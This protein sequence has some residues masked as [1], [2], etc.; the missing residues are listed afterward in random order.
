MA[1]V[2]GVMAASTAP[3][4]MLNVAGSMSTNTGVPPALWMAPAVAKKV[5]GV[6]ITSSPGWRS[7]ALSGS[8]R[9]SVPLAQPMACLVWESRGH[10]GLELRHL[11][12]HDEA[13]ALD[14]R[15]DGREHLVLDAAVLRDQIQ[16]GNVHRC[17]PWKKRPR[18]G[19]SGRATGAVKCA[20]PRQP[21]NLDVR[22][23]WVNQAQQARP[24]PGIAAPHAP[25]VAAPPRQHEPDAAP[26]HPADPPGRH[27]DHQRV[28]RHVAP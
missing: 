26:A 23:R 21:C 28:G 20:N 2:R 9:A 11:G 25:Q 18:I 8:S 1:R 5:N 13:L 24:P 12:A 16:Q 7:S 6:V 22:D 4:A 3:G 17:S 15:H 27:A 14:H 10:G 19:R